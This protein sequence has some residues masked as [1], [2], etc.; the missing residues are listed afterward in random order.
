MAKRSEMVAATLEG[1]RNA[2]HEYR[3]WC[4]EW[5][6][7]EPVEGYVASH[8]A[9]ALADCR[10]EN[11]EVSL[12]EKFTSLRRKALP[13]RAKKGKPHKGFKKNQ[14]AD[15]VYWV[16]GRPKVAIEVK[17]GHDWTGVK[18]DLVR[19]RGLLAEAG[20]RVGGSLAVCIVCH[21]KVGKW[22]GG[23]E[24]IDVWIAK[25]REKFKAFLREKGHADLLRNAHPKEIGSRFKASDPQKISEP[26]GRGREDCYYEVGC[27]YLIAPA[28][29]KA[30]G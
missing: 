15:V 23:K 22:P 30:K 7:D 28:D 17:R 10:G 29:T 24:A 21:Y 26:A 5:A 6:S 13:G 14:R 3:T 1:L 19:M 20:P 16:E 12:E 11:A 2:N 18:R 27:C 25:R 8:V 9:R 4:D